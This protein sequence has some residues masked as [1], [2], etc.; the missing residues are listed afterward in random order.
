MQVFRFDEG[1]SDEQPN[2]FSNLYE[3]YKQRYE[4]YRSRINS[5]DFH[6]VQDLRN[7]MAETRQTIVEVEESAVATATHMAGNAYSTV[8]A[9]GSNVDKKLHELSHATSVQFT[10]A[11][12]SVKEMTEGMTERLETANIL[13][14]QRKRIRQQLKGYR[15]LLNRMIIQSSTIPSKQMAA[16]MRKITE[17]N[18]AIERLEH[19]ARDAFAKATGY[20]QKNILHSKEPQ[21]YAK[22]SSDPLLGIASYPLAFHLLILGAT[23]IPLRAM[24]RNRGFSRLKLGPVSYYFHPGSAASN[25][26]DDETGRTPLIFVHGIGIGLIMYKSLIDCLLKSGRAIFLPEIPYVS[27]FRPWQSPNAVLSPA[28]VASTMTA[29]LAT[30]GYLRGAFV[31]HS[32]GTSWLSYMIKYSPNA[33]AAA[34]FLDPIC[35]CLHVPRLTKQFVYH[36]PDPGSI[37][38]M[39]RTDV[40]V[41][42]TIQRS[43]PWTRVVLFTED[44]QVPCAVFLSDRDQLVPAG[45]IEN[46]LQSKGAPIRDFEKA[47]MDFFSEGDINVSVFRG[48]GHGDWTERPCTSPK[49]AECAEVLCCRA[50]A[51]LETV[52]RAK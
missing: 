34:L 52:Q 49:I 30:H 45:K 33:I 3:N 35:F 31:G 5:A 24:L 14:S 27:G 1:H 41:N 29:I 11:W 51:R 25:D 4:Q 6:P 19:S 15:L 16:L 37:N 17:C 38:Y 20:A 46:Y 42:W 23:E 36:R 40:T 26:L 48:D 18:E 13:S 32:Y 21:R 50:E 7:F 10:E 44:I 43:F 47:D 22:Y 9:P 28:V 8:V 12:N 2:F 39:V